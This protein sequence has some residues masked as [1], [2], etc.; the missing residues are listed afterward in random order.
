MRKTI[1]RTLSVVAV[2]ALA[3]ACGGTGGTP[4]EIPGTGGG[5]GGGGTSGGSGGGGGGGAGGVP[6]S[7]QPWVQIMEPGQ[8]VD[9]ENGD[10]D[11]WCMGG[12]G[13]YACEDGAPAGSGGTPPPGWGSSSGGSGTSGSSG[14]SGG[15]GTGASSSSGGSG[16][17]SGGAPICDAEQFSTGA[18][19]TPQLLLV[20]D[21]S[22]SMDEAPSGQAQTKWTQ[23]T[24]VL[25]GVVNSL[26]SLVDFGLALFPAVGGDACSPGDVVVDIASDSAWSITSTLSQYGPGGGTPTGTSLQ[27]ALQYLRGRDT[28]RPRAVV[29]AT[30]GAP[31]CTYSYDPNSCVCTNPQGCNDSRNC[32]DATGAVSAVNALASEG[33]STFV[34]GIPGTDAYASV[35]DQMAVAG[36]TALPAGGARYYRTTNQS[37]LQSALDAISTRIAACRFE[38]QNPPDTSE[39][40]Q[41]TIDGIPV[42]YSAS[43]SNGYDLTGGRTVEFFGQACDGLAQGGSHTVRVEYCFHPGG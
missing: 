30:D 36:G 28:T 8:S 14:T 42:N 11:G 2:A 41:V 27:Q 12:E 16:S 39:S 13:P 6:E 34:V 19:V 1:T 24:G 29:L 31:N 20:V 40:F 32:L 43:H 18:R 37:D 17:A 10:A 26:Q 33:I 25:G 23:V 7:P 5:G 15:S 38:L 3:W 9:D 22:G 21:K 35:L 4:G